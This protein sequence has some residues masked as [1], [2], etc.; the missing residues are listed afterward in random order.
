RQP[1]ILGALV[2]AAQ[3]CYDMAVIYDTP[4]I[5]GKD[6]L[7]NEFEDEG[8]VISI[9][10]TLLISAIGVMDDVNR[11]V[12]MDFKNSGNLIY[13]VGTTWNEMGGSE[14]LRLYH[15]TGNSVPRVR[16]HQAKW[17]ME[18]LATATAKGLVRACHD[19]SEGGI[20]VAV[21]EMAFA[22]GLGAL[23]HLKHV[24]LG[25]PVN[26]DDF[27]LFSESNSR[28]LV[29][30]APDDEEQFIEIMKESINLASIGQVTDSETLEIYGRGGK[31]VLEQKIN[32]LKEA[33]QKP[34]RW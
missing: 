18:R 30:V 2:R 3:A 19:C 6:S 32:E 1:D 26:R 28:F 16:P 11:A 31:R 20:G 17:L 22:G 33:W 23:V 21:A 29:E 5:S 34:I 14:Y 10:H 9:P 7:Y 24:P 25:E 8:K 12:S 15:L 13:I 27:I 4:F